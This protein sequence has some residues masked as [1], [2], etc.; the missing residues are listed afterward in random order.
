MEVSSFLFLIL[1]YGCAGLDA[2]LTD[3]DLSSTT[4]PPMAALFI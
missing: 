4:D 1:E 2:I 3:Y